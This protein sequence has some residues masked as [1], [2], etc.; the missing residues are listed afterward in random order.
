[1]RTVGSARFV[2]GHRVSASTIPG[3]LYSVLPSHDVFPKDEFDVEVRSLFPVHLKTAEVRVRVAPGLVIVGDQFARDMA[4]QDMFLGTVDRNENQASISLVRKGN[5]PIDGAT[6]GGGTDELLFTLR[7]RAGSAAK[8]GSTAAVS[9]YVIRLKD[10]NE[11]LVPVVVG[12]AIISRA[13]VSWTS[14]GL[15]HFSTDSAVAV[16]AHTR[17][18]AELVNTAVLSHAPAKHGIRVD[19]VSKRGRV[20]EITK[21]ASC[22]VPADET[23]AVIS[24]AGC[25]LAFDGTESRGAAD[26]AVEVEYTGMRSRVHIRVLYPGEVAAE[27]TPRLIRPVAGWHNEDDGTCSS[28]RYA[29]CLLAPRAAAAVI[30]L[31][32]CGPGGPFY[33]RA[34]G[35]GD[36]DR[37]VYSQPAQRTLVIRDVTSDPPAQVR[38]RAALRIGNVQ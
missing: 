12:G 31:Q 8:A 4:G 27:A 28:L 7:V 38:P 10:G 2:A 23:P 35:F 37:G 16:F 17:K 29:A 5:T 36:G 20:V 6:A 26:V 14:P 19:T 24:V 34:A 1:M 18:G 13:G 33:S 11:A 32:V 25:T 21:V 30:F 15:V 9:L 3:T 22:A